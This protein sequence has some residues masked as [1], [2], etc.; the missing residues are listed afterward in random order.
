MS[1]PVLVLLIVAIIAAIVL[2]C[3]GNGVHDGGRLA[4]SP[5][6]ATSVARLTRCSL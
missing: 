5:P 1:R 4:A 2:I 3:G 6:G